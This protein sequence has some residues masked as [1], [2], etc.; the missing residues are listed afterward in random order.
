MFG[1]KEMCTPAT[2]YF[3]LSMLAIVVMLFQ[4][5]G[6]E[7]LYCLG[8]YNC[9]VSSVTLIF[10]AKIL[11]IFLWTWI[12]NLICKAGVPGLSWF[13]V[14]FPFIVF[15]ILLSSFMFYGNVQ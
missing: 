15:F 11:Y 3:S 10:I 4:N 2:V 9:Q 6:S 12:L 13:L 8:V 5:V 1:F 7:N 14:L